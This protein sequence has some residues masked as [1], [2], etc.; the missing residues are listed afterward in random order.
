MR[1][2]LAPTALEEILRCGAHMGPPSD[3]G[4]CHAQCPFVTDDAAEKDE[5]RPKILPA[6]WIGSTVEVVEVAPL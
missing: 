2:Q 5:G 4:V 6:W 1:A 3:G